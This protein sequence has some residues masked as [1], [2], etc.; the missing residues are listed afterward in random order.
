MTGRSREQFRQLALR[1]D[2]FNEVIAKASA[3]M[4]LSMTLM[5]F[6]ITVMRYG[7]KTGS[8]ALQESVV[9]MHAIAFL[10]TTAYALRRRYHVRVDVFYNNYPARRKAI[11][12]LVGT[13]LLLFPFIILWFVISIEYVA[14]SW[15]YWERSI[16]AVGLPGVFLLKTLIL[17]TPFMLFLQGLS[18]I[19][20]NVL[21]L[22]GHISEAEW[23]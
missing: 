2:R 22:K 11:T 8:V 1:F 5:Y 21:F 9:Y 7:F 19:I 10:L 15:K 3:W 4:L 17:I 20:R 14:F 6:L 18:D 23:R 13:L 16:E 12:D